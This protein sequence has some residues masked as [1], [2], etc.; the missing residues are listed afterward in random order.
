[1]HIK[2]CTN[3]TCIVCIK[4]LCTLEHLGQIQEMQRLQVC[5][6]RETHKI[7]DFSM[8]FLRLSFPKSQSCFDRIKA[9]QTISSIMFFKEDKQIVLAFEWPCVWAALPRPSGRRATLAAALGCAL[10]SA[11]ECGSGKTLPSRFRV[12]PRAQT[13]RQITSTGSSPA[14]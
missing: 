1:V 12:P 10:S 14:L 6:G 4:G 9:K 11:L 2:L 8:L 7:V 13:E 5:N 3:F